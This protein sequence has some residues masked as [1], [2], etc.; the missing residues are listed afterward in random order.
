MTTTAHSSGIELMAEVTCPNCWEK[1]PPESALAV[2]G[3]GD[4]MGDPRLEDQKETRRF[5][6]TRFTPEC[7]ALDEKDTP[8]LELACPHCHLLVPRVIFERRDTVFLSIFGRSQSGK[9]YFL[10]A[11]AQQMDTALPQ[12]FG[13]GV[14]QPHPASNALIQWYKNRLF[15]NPDPDALVDI[16]RTDISGIRYYQRVRYGNDV[17]QYPRPMFFQV[18]PTGRHPH[19][20]KP[21]RNTRTICLYDNSGEHFRAGHATP[22]NPETE[23]LCRSSALLFVFDPTRE[24]PF[25]E[26]CR[27]TSNDPQFAFAA[28]EAANEP[29]DV[30]LA[31][32]DA[33]VKKRLGREIAEPLDTP[34]VV[35]LAKFDAWRH[36][37][38]GDLPAFATGNEGDFS[39]L[40]GFKAGEVERV[41]GI[42]RD[43][44]MVMCPSIVATAERFSRRVCYIPTSATGCSPIVTGHDPE[45]G[46]PSLKV[47]RG[48][49]RPIWAEVPLLWILDQLTVGLVPTARPKE[50]TR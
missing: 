16:P 27:D 41:S 43:L 47:R 29:Q 9:S 7:A 22:N 36:L 20:A 50:T 11:M 10:A 24:P 25:I 1:F 46:E 32:A 42:M 17:R 19:A 5:V 40:N 37:V 49:L 12:R 6:P 34:L 15:N 4:L 39:T 21:L 48:S 14:T 26:R 8:S 35:I 3:H 33:N 23:H 18:T 44:L 45:S 13:L 31:T 2:A 30:I 28:K 38:A